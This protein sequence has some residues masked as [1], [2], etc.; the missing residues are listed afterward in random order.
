MTVAIRLILFFLFI[1]LVDF[2]AFQAIKSAFRTMPWARYVYWGLSAVVYLYLLVII[3]RFD[4][5][6]G[7]HNGL[8]KYFLGLFILFLVPKLILLLIMFGEDVIRVL[9]GT[10][11]KI[12]GSEGSFL[13]ERRKF[14][15]Q[16]ALGL[17]AI[18]FLGIL[19]GI[20]RGRY[21][22]KVMRKTVEF[23]DLPEAFDGLQI[24]Q[25]SDVH[26]GSFDNAEKVRYGI[27]LINEQKSDI[28]FFTGDLVN[29]QAD[30]MLP[31]IK[32]FSRLSAPMGKF[33]ILGNHDYGDYVNW[34][35]EAAKEEN[36]RKLYAIHKELGFNLLRNENTSIT[37]GSQK[38]N[39]LGVEN[40]GSGGFVQYGDLDKASDKVMD[41]EFNILLSHDPSHFEEVVK[42]FSKKMQLTLSGHTHGM[43]FGIEIPGVI[44]WSP[45]QYR[46]PKW[47]GL[48]EEL[49]RKLYVNRGFGY[50]AFPGRVGIWPEITV[51]TL[52]RKTA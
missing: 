14:V 19:H 24:T 15:G 36:M 26:S 21:N 8:F 31:W 42:K 4:R 13:P 9:V 33:S 51:L 39:I 52:K 22:Y 30:E 48:Y 43:Q 3:F 44:R 35:S 29:N 27:D 1:A 49:G 37:R 12:K 6:A 28:I 34:P 25:I 50:L 20:V 47:A 7:P 41:D 10:V 32:E 40:W 2:Y 18:P 5:D 11:Q 46:Y 45:V 38:L 17:A 16:I 23:D